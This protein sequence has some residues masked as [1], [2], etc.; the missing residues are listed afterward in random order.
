MGM[1]IRFWYKLVPELQPWGFLIRPAS[2][3]DQQ[4]SWRQPVEIAQHGI[5]H[6]PGI[7][8]K[9]TA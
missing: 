5:P 7:Q 1:Q 3:Q 8:A 2:Q 4:V 9:L 6:K